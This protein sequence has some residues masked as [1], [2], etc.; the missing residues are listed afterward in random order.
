VASQD[1]ADAQAGSLVRPARQSIRALHGLRLTLLKIKI[2][3]IVSTIQTQEL[4]LSDSAIIKAATYKRTT[5]CDF[6]LKT[7]RDEFGIIIFDPSDGMML[8]MHEDCY[9][10]SLICED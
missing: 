10:A 1:Q 7:I 9:K 8:S 3:Q 5:R 4:V 6:C 2:K